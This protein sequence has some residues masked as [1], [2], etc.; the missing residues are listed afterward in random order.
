MNV[1]SREVVYLSFYLFRLRCPPWSVFFSLSP[2]CRL[3]WEFI[4]QLLCDD[5]F[6]SYVSWER[7]EEY[8]FRINNPTGEFK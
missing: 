8:V 1:F 7:Q 4:Y 3:L 6:S 2:D 5:K